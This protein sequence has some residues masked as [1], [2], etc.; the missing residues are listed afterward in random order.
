MRFS[1][2]NYDHAFNAELVKLKEEGRYRE[3]VPLSRMMGDFP[4]ALWHC[5]ETQQKEVVVWCTNDYLNMSH[6]KQVVRAFQEAAQ[7]FGVGSGGTRN[8]AGT[9]Y[10]HL[11]LENEM[12]DLHQKD[13]AL[14]FSSGYAANEGALSALSNAFKDM[15]IFSDEKNHASM[16]QG[17]REGKGAYKIFKHNDMV[18]LESLIKDLP[19][20]QP[21][22]IAVTSVYPML[23]DFANLEELCDLAEQYNAL[24]YVDEVHAM[25]IY[26]PEGDGLV[27]HFNLQD[28]VHIIQGNFAKGYGAIGGYIAGSA[29]IVDYIRSFASSFIFTTSLPPATTQAALESVKYLRKSA[30]EREKLW[31]N[32]ALLKDS[33]RHHHVPFIKNE[34]HIVAVIIGGASHCKH[35]CDRLLIEYGIYLQP[36]NYPTVPL[37]QEMVRITITPEHSLEM[38]NALAQA[39]NELLNENKRLE[40]A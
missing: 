13:A 20:S 3:F 29:S 40:A 32:V 12:A 39:L 2:L 4:Y 14:T 19:L 25:G 11:L 30:I 28:K 9:S 10:P 18:H 34:S 16:I 1:L 17:I 21:K 22:L 6:N 5:N 38:I 35:F 37:G 27:A 7:Y 26:G 33:L 31:Q 24:L 8:I 23:G 15:I 36:I